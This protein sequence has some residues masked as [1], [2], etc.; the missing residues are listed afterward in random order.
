MSFH[1]DLFKS[2]FGEKL[3][4]GLFWRE[5]TEKMIYCYKANDYI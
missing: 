1:D 4:E 3:E 5:K 2:K